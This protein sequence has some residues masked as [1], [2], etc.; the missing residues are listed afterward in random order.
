M[1]T[2]N[3]HDRDHAFQ[4]VDEFRAGQQ[5]GR[6][7]QGPGPDRDAGQPD[8]GAVGQVL[9]PGAGVLR[10]ANHLDHL[11]E[12]GVASG[13]L[14]LD[15]QGGFPVEG[16]ADNLGA[17][18]FFDRSA[19]ARNHGLVHAAVAVHHRSVDGNLFAGL[20]QDPVAFLEFRDR[21]LFGVTPCGQSV[22]LR[23][24][25]LDQFVQR[26]GSAHDRAH[27]DPVPEEHDDDQGGQL[28]EEGLAGQTEDDRRAVSVGHHNGQP[29]QGH[30]PRPAIAEFIDQSLQKRPAAVEENSRGKSEKD[31]ALPGKTQTVTQ[32]QELL[33]QRRQSE[34]G[35]TQGQGNPEPPPEILHHVGVMGLTLVA[36]LIGMIV[37][38]MGVAV[39][40]GLGTGVVFSGH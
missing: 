21:H 24:Y 3:H 38:S 16:A 25:Q 40:A 4:R 19:F 35:K 9:G 2:G 28:P 20:D 31:V 5:P 18:G 7:C 26:S 14:N 6:Q 27:L 11:G 33:N 8:G 32:A 37:G 23:R 13:F 36:A 1:R 10:L 29:D 39:F 15:G 22:R 17:G 12:I 34:D 30:H